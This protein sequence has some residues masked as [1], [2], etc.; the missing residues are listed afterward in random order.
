M[1]ER[2]GTSQ[3]VDCELQAFELDE[4][5]QRLCRP[6]VNAVIRRGSR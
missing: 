6:R 3:L 4:L 1:P 2:E 5:E